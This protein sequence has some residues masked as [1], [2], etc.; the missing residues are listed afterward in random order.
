MSEE[1]PTPGENPTPPAGDTPPAGEGENQFKTEE[2][3]SEEER[4]A[5]AADEDYILGFKQEDYS[6]PAK[7]EKLEKAI[8]SARTTIHQKRHYRTKYN[9]VKG[10]NNPTPPA[11][12]KKPDDKTPVTPPA[13]DDKKKSEVTN[14][15][16]I[17]FR[18]DNP[19]VSREVAKEI[20]EYAK[21]KGITT[22]EAMKSSTIKSLIK[23]KT[24]KSEIEDA[25]VT[26]KPGAGGN[27]A[28]KDWSNASQ[29]DINKERAKMGM[30]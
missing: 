17:D 30:E 5:L 14:V 1:N 16:I 15:E 11:T 3:M 7:V 9:E 8:A 19:E 10:G 22:E 12:E 29:E 2:D 6:D 27:I 4:T 18:Q 24:T 21:F 23:S 26:P 25:G 20:L 13:S 28:E